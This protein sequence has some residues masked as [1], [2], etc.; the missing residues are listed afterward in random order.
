MRALGGPSFEWTATQYLLASILDVLAVANWQRSGGKAHRPKPL[1]R[2]GQQTKKRY[3]R[4]R[5]TPTQLRER[6][7]A[8]VERVRGEITETVT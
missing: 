4:H 5:Y 6:L 1:E 7:A 3:G 2:P 8:R